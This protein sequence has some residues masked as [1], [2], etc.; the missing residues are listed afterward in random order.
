MSN[1]KDFLVEENSHAQKSQIRLTSA[2]FLLQSD[3]KHPEASAPGVDSLIFNWN[4][5]ESAE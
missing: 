3:M 4:I 2:L 5:L 1:N